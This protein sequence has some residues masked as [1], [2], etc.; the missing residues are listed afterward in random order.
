LG[1]LFSEASQ[2]NIENVIGI[3]SPHAGYVFSGKI[4][5]EAF[6]QID[7]KKEYD[8][9]FIIS[10]SHRLH[11]DGASIYYIGNYNMPMGQVK[12]N[13]TL[14]KELIDKY[15]CFTYRREAHLLEHSIE[16]Q[17]PFLQHKLEKDF[18]IVPII[19]GTNS[20]SVIDEIVDALKPYF[21]SRNLFVISTDF[22]HYPSYEDAKNIDSLTIDAILK[23]NSDSLLNVLSLNSTKP[24]GGLSTSLC[25]W[26][27][28]LT[29]LKLTEEHEAIRTS[30]VAYANSGDSPYGDHNRV[31]GYGAIV[32]STGSVILEPEN[33][34]D[35][36][37]GFQLTA[38]EKDELLNLARKT[39]TDYI[40]DGTIQS[41]TPDMFSA[42]LSEKCGVFVSLYLQGKELRG[43]IGRFFTDDPIFQT[44]QQMTIASAVQDTRFRPVSEQEL[45]HI[46][47][48]ISVL[49]PMQ[50][51]S[52]VDEIEL[53]KH[54]IY[55]KKGNRSGT[56]L[57]QVATETGW[58]IEEFVGHCSRDKAGLGWDG[59]RTAELFVYTALVF[60][61]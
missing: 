22:S 60:G 33:I 14:S 13:R 12:V 9:I 17:L 20:M 10:S 46:K 54:G 4:A 37:K 41:L 44:V 26:S 29:L 32:F 61:E 51:I 40:H 15:S 38:S 55:I 53:G 56:F 47:I 3:L 30:L 21:N 43:C 34:M 11:F 25:G 50:A 8:N 57:P 24:I 18:Q 45:E 49:S 16:V 52:S 36:I 5:A 19:I 7:S 23:N 59:W 58:N 28:V 6:N 35:S 42:R 39:L 48:E 31:V 2:K 27:S 1:L